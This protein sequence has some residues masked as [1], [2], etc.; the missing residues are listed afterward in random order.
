MLLRSFFCSFRYQ[1]KKRFEKLN[2]V[3]KSAIYHQFIFKRNLFQWESDSKEACFKRNMFP[4]CYM[5]QCF[6]ICKIIFYLC[7][8]L[9]FSGKLY[10]TNAK[11]MFLI[12]MLMLIVKINKYVINSFLKNFA[13][14]NNINKLI[15]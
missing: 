4:I 9:V 11:I 3:R 6:F 5:K 13:R 15:I 1:R 14:T 12:I 10:L 8:T 7:F 2:I